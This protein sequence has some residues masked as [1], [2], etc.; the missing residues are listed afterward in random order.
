MQ[1]PPSIAEMLDLAD[2]RAAVAVNC[3]LLSRSTIYN[4][5]PKARNPQKC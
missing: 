2:G 5:P 3:K 1:K 4:Q